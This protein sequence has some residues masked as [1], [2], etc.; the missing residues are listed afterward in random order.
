MDILTSQL[1]SGG[2]GYDFPSIS[3]SPMT[4]LEVCKYLENVPKDPLDKYLYDIRLLIDE[5]EK[6]KKCYMMDV[7]FL[8]FYKKLCTVSGDLSYQISITC[9]HCKNEIKK[10]IS[11]D[12]DI[13]FKQIDPKIMKG[14]VINLNGSRYDTIIPTVEDFMKVFSVY[15]RYRKVTDLKMIKT[16]ALIS[17]FD[18]QGNKIENDVLGATHSDITLLLA[19]RELYYDQLEPVEVFCPHCNKGLKKNERRSVAVSVESLIVD[20]FRDLTIN[21][22]IDAT[23]ILFK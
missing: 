3:V 18:L 10:T 4:F 1:P 19:L 9:P 22:P 6:I 2:Y 5:D 8:I 17:G 15:L 23:K 20:F 11:F 7:D 21:S 13:H 12:K 14:A 16:M